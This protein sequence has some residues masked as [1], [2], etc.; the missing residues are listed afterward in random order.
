MIRNILTTIFNFFKRKKHNY[1]VYFRK[2]I[3]CYVNTK[4]EAEIEIRNLYDNSIN[5][6][7][8]VKFIKPSETMF[9]NFRSNF[10]IKKC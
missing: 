8:T 1:V 4:D 3:F 5:I 2:E 6:H 10:N 7:N 9:K